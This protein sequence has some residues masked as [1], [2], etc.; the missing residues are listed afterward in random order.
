M[1][2][3]VSST[4][5]ARI[6]TNA[7]IIIYNDTGDWEVIHNNHNIPTNYG[8]IEEDVYKPFAVYEHCSNYPLVHGIMAP[9]Q[10][11]AI[12]E[13]FSILTENDGEEPILLGLRPLDFS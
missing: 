12:Q 13:V 2:D 3:V 1:F 7:E 8:E 4:L 11:E 6:N 9:S 5:K 10:D